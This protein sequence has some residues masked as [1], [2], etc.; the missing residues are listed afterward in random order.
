M[1]VYTTAAGVEKDMDLDL[2]RIIAYEA[3]H[4]DWSILDLVNSMKRFR[5]SDL[6]LMASFLGYDSFE[7]FSADGFTVSDMADMVT[8]SRYLGFTDSP[9][10]E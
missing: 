6:N 3:E 7:A 4:P 9:S 10:E 5:F 8:G 1:T 2:D